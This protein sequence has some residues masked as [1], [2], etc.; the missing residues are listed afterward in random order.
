MTAQPSRRR[1]PTKAAITRA[2]GAAE[3]AGLTDYRV[4]ILS[5][6]IVLVSGSTVPETEAD[7]VERQMVQAFGR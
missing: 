5:D 1:A 2:V 4:E 3:K 6:R 7:R